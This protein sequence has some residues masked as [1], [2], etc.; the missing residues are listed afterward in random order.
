MNSKY[1]IIRPQGMWKTF[2]NKYNTAYVQN[3]YN[4]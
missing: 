1:C 2:R 3:M 4:K